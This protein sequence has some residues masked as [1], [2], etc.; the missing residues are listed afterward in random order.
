MHGKH[1]GKT[2]STKSKLKE[3]KQTATE[4]HHITKEDKRGK[5]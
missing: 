1:K 4:S 2:C 5:G 3:S